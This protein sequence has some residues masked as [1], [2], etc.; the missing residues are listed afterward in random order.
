VP[1]IKLIIE[2]N[3][4]DRAL[5]MQ[6]CKELKVFGFTRP[7][8][9]AWGGCGRRRIRSWF[10]LYP[11]ALAGGGLRSP[12]RA[13]PS[14]RWQQESFESLFAMM[15]TRKVTAS[16]RSRRGSLFTT[17]TVTTNERS[18]CGNLLDRH[19]GLRPP[20]DDL[21]FRLCEPSKK[22]WQSRRSP[23]RTCALLAMTLWMLA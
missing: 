21:S 20:R 4:K 23:R 2:L 7:E 10:Q 16:L 3:S 13:S 5:I 17:R 12:R 6:A 18:E 22:A 8:W 14:S 9:R 15:T 11:N 1:V 19:V